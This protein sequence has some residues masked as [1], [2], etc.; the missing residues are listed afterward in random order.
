MVRVGFGTHGGGAFMSTPATSR[1]DDGW[2]FVLLFCAGFS[3]FRSLPST[4]DVSLFLLLFFVHFSLVMAIA[5]YCIE[6]PGE[7]RSFQSMN[8]FACQLN[9]TQLSQLGTRSLEMD[10]SGESSDSFR[11]SYDIIAP[12]AVVTWWPTT[13]EKSEGASCMSYCRNPM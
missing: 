5:N 12:N 3:Q 10:R 13:Q 1:G 4:E 8:C 9:S 7:M 11:G 2:R 6:K